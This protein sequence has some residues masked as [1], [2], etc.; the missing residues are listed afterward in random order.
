LFTNDSSLKIFLM[1]FDA[2]W[3]KTQTTTPENVSASAT[4]AASIQVS[5]TPIVYNADTGGYRVF[6]STTPGGPYT[7]F[8]TT[9]DKTVSQ[10]NVTGLNPAT[11]YYFLVQTR[12]NPH[13]DN[14][15]TVDSEYNA[16]VSAATTGILTITSA[17][18][19]EVLDAGKTGQITWDAVGITEHLKLTLWQN[20]VK[21]GNIALINDLNARS[22]SWMVGEH[23]GGVTDPGTGFTIKISE[24]GTQAADESDASFEIKKFIGLTS[25]NGGETWLSGTY[26]DITWNLPAS[27]SGSFVL[28]LMKDGVKVGNIALITDPA[29]GSYSWPVGKYIGGTAAPGT[30]YTVKMKT[31]TKSDVSD[32]PFEIKEFSGLL[33]PNGGEHLLIGT[34]YD[35]S[36]NLPSS[37]S[38]AIVLVLLKDGVKVGN[39]AR[40]TDPAVRSYSWTIG[41][42]IGGIAAAGTGYKIK[43]KLVGASDVSDTTFDLSD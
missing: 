24:I 23:M 3:E 20:G 30:G 43:L 21:V 18:G 13:A 36:W 35:I 2:D 10:M 15:N 42:Y 16:E 6:Y 31:G 26:R 19:G 7:L 40:L 33:S 8:D 4:G 34:T 41:E 27:F 22:Y 37:Y 28:V 9:T 17:N 5:W 29:S 11:T 25:P 12:T 38:G 1:Q 39:I 14:Q 32:G